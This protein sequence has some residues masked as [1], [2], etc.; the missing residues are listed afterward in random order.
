MT[1]CSCLSG[2][3]YRARQAADHVTRSGTGKR[4]TSLKTKLDLTYNQVYHPDFTPKVGN[5]SVA[6]EHN[7]D[8]FH[9][10]YMVR[11]VHI[12]FSHEVALNLPMHVKREMY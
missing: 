9:T 2:V 3:A 11:S 12:V 6:G 5:S 8:D 7:E 1:W 4:S 10:P